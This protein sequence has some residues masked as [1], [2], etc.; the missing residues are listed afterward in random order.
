[1]AHAVHTTHA[2]VLGSADVQDADRLFWLLTEDLGLLFASAKSVREET[3]KLRY[4]LQDLSQPRV[5]LVRGR[6][7]WRLTG[8]EE[9]GA[10]KLNLAASKVFGRIAALIRRVMPTDE[11]NPEVFAVV[12]NARKALAWPKADIQTIERITVARVLYQL[13]YLSCTQEYRGIV[14]SLDYGEEVLERGDELG[15]KLIHDINA[16]LAESQL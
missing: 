4:A 12:S 5:S 7:L 2:L 14:D 13:G 10:E 8:A 1:M 16:G 6:G 9:N 15:Q 3:S 11:D